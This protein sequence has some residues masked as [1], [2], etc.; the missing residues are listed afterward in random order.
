M[1][2]GN[3]DL[4][5][6]INFQREHEKDRA[7]L[8]SAIT[9]FML[10][11][12][13][14]DFIKRRQV[15]D[16]IRQRFEQGA[17]FCR[18]KDDRLFYFSKNERRL[19]DLEGS[20]FE[21]LTSD[22]T[23]LGKTESVY[24]FTLHS[25]KTAAARTKALDVHTTAHFDPATG[26]LA[27]S[28]AATGVWI[29]ER[30]GEWRYT[31]NGDNGLLF[32]TE[33]DAEPFD[34][35][36]GAD[37]LQLGWFLDQFLLAR[38]DPLSAED[39][40]TLL[41]VNLLHGFFPAL[42]RTRPIP[43]FLGPQGS[44]KTSGVKLQGRLIVGPRFEV[45]GLRREKE[46]AFIAAL[47][48]RV[49]VGFDNA[50]TRVPWL[51]DAL[52]VYATGQRY[53]LRRL[54][55]TNDEV[56]YDPRAAI[57]ITSR[58]PHFNRPDVSERLLPF[59]FERP[60]KYRPEESIF[61]EL[62]SRRN[63][64][65]GEIF[66]QLAAIADYVGTC[67]APP[68]AFR[69][70]DFAAFGWS[71]FALRDRA[72]DWI[73]LLGRL[74]RAQAGFAAENDGLIEALRQLLHHRNNQIGPITTGDL[75]KQCAEIAET[76]RLAFPQT[77]QAF[78]RR[79]TAAQRTIELELKCRFSE[80]TGHRGQRWI[81]LTPRAGGDGDD[82]DEDRET[83]TKL[84]QEEPRFGGVGANGD[85]VPETITKREGSE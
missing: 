57:L 75:Y 54:Y 1:N 42:R 39:Q 62:E 81:T 7:N 70:A 31:H 55:T 46:D 11:K 67:K 63:A 80:E 26:F 33:P 74:E 2:I 64:I 3:E 32:L 52:A 5:S 12:E 85:D 84:D 83:F 40:R 24:G 23:G 29:R 25:L 14:K 36:F 65:W 19:Y 68:L 59:Y 66:A 18:T 15:A 34:P 17:F 41:L 16:L 58:D 60:A 77:A 82:G 22:I 49:I 53:R 35:D 69:M 48:N 13:N 28:D 61:S 8:R 78:G 43:G 9:C 73:D 71:L 37:G 50:D 38:H 79:F 4:D 51:E 44:G 45:T 76:E 72:Q 30:H 20:A 27:V 47:C 6:V 10:D 21:Y 56:S